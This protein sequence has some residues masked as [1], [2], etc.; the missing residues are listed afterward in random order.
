MFYQRF[1]PIGLTWIYV[2]IIY[3][4]CLFIPLTF[5]LYVGTAIAMILASVKRRKDWPFHYHC[6]RKPRQSIYYSSFQVQ[7]RKE[8]AEERLWPY[9][10]A[11]TKE[12]K[13]GTVESESYCVRSAGDIGKRTYVRF[14]TLQG[15]ID[16]NREGEE[17]VAADSN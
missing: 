11:C 10:S 7:V 2:V 9:N 16:L 1:R 14:F 3:S 4:I 5:P 6:L 8:T 13:R 17:N 12:R 15:R